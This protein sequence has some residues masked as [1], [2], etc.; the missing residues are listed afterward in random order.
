MRTR[1][2]RMEGGHGVMREYAGIDW[3]RARVMKG[4]RMGCG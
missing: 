4:C 1:A 3:L 2:L